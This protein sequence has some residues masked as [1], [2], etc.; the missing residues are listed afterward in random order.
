M[1]DKRDLINSLAKEF[2]HVTSEDLR[3]EETNY[4]STSG[5]LDCRATAMSKE[6]LQR[7]L[8]VI[9]QHIKKF[10]AMNNVEKEQYVAHLTVAKRCV[11]EV[12]SMKNKE[13]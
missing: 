6:T 1:A 11:E 5:S 8:R 9:E 7:T 3:I 2:G 10:S 13:G 4:I 12:I